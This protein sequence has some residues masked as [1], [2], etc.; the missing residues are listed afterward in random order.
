A[1]ILFKKYTWAKVFENIRYTGVE[2]VYFASD[3]GQPNKP[4]V[5]DGLA[6]AAD[7]ALDA[8]FSKDEIHRMF[9]INSG[10]LVESF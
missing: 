4:P 6:L 2:Q 1:S 9:V 3:L 7:Q 8:G 5:E 10:R